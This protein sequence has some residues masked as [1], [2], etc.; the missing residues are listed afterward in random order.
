M[1]NGVTDNDGNVTVK[2]DT[3]TG[4]E[5]CRYCGTDLPAL[6]EPRQSPGSCYPC[7]IKQ[8]VK[9]VQSASEGHI[10]ASRPALEFTGRITTY[11]RIFYQPAN[12]L[13]ALSKKAGHPVFTPVSKPG[14][15]CCGVFKK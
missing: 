7:A 2:T 5:K 6:Q 3:V 12:K 13:E 4:L 9:A 15:A 1:S 14:Y 10:L 11:E 8:P